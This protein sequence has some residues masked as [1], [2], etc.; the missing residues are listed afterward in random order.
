M[1]NPTN[2]AHSETL[3]TAAYAFLRVL[4]MDGQDTTMTVSSA[5]T[6]IWK[7]LEGTISQEEKH[8]S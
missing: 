7:V 3:V 8:G 1:I 4:G 6:Q 5:F 2:A